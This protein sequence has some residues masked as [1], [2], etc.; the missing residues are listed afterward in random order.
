MRA[1]QCGGISRIVTEM[2]RHLTQDI[3]DTGRFM[4]MFYISIDVENKNLSWVRAGHDPAIIYDPSL[5]RFEELSGAG[6][7]LG[8]DESY[9]FEENT[10][11]G[12]AQGQIIAIGTDGIWET[13]NK[14]GEMFG[15][16]RFREI[17]R[18]NAYMGSNEILN[19][20]FNEIDIFSKGLK[21][22]DDITLVIIK[23]E[24]TSEEGVD[25]QI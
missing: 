9:I 21:K 1:S 22:K 19:A 2:N 10:K 16:G 20:V 18:K 4:T 7:A 24:E 6:L 25:W 8:I 17:I 12:L 5:D 13:F 15:K 23:I 11:A 3:L 14:Q